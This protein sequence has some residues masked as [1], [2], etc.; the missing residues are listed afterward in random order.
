M[1]LFTQLFEKK[2]L[3]TI[4]VEH[5]WKLLSRTYAQPR[6]DATVLAQLNL[7]PEILEKTLCGVTTYLWEC[8]NT[9]EL[10]R[11]QLLG[12]DNDELSDLVERVE[13]GGMQYI[14]MNGNVYAIAKWVEPDKTN[15]PVK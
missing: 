6:R 1:N 2:S 3:E 14:R 9:K 7:P 8:Q 11:E 15:V 13:K 12:N 4:P 5:D 10:R